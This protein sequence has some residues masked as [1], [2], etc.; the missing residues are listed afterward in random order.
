MN[1]N[2]HFNTK[3]THTHTLVISWPAVQAIVALM[4]DPKGVQLVVGH[5]I[6]GRERPIGYG[7]SFPIIP[8]GPLIQLWV[9][10]L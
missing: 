4:L 8:D 9:A 2:T 7:L 6:S 10:H 3:H 5:Q 1:R